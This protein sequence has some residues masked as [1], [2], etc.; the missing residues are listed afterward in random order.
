MQ[1]WVV[2]EQV[3]EGKDQQ[4]IGKEVREG[5]IDEVDEMFLYN[6]YKGSI[7]YKYQVKSPVGGYIGGGRWVGGPIEEIRYQV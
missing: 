1:N 6:N 2:E 7:K 3:E 5:N 4:L